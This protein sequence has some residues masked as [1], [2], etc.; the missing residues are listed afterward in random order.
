MKCELTKNFS[1]LDKKA[2]IESLSTVRPIWPHHFT[3]SILIPVTQNPISG[4]ACYCLQTFVLERQRK[5]NTVKSIYQHFSVFFSLFYTIYHWNYAIF[6]VACLHI[7]ELHKSRSHHNDASKQMT[8]FEFMT[9]TKLKK[10]IRT[11]IQPK[12]NVMNSPESIIISYI[13]NLS[14]ICEFHQILV[15][16]K[17]KPISMNWE[18][19]FVINLIFCRE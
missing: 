15:N 2:F 6:D 3:H 9:I 5:V 17:T 11:M 14:M 12:Q 19:H 13:M 10:H 4:I 18:Q 16:N 8:K 1:F 7:I